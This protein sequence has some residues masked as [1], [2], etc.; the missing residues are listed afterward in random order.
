MEFRFALCV[1]HS[2][3]F[4][5]EKRTML[6]PALPHPFATAQKPNL[7]PQKTRLDVSSLAWYSVLRALVPFSTSFFSTLI[8][9]NRVL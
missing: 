9:T 2:C 4:F 1:A 5:P 6:R 8:L 7:V 3:S